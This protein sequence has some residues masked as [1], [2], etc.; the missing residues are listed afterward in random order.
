LL[1]KR[2]S[3]EQCSLAQASPRA[4]NCSGVR[5]SFSTRSWINRGCE[6]ARSLV[7]ATG[8]NSYFLLDDFPP[9]DLPPLD[10]DFLAPAPF[11]AFEDAGP[12]LASEYVSTKVSS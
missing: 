7:L 2:L 3:S 9:R 5:I 12:D 11:A 1:T 8:V 4:S 6:L 10:A